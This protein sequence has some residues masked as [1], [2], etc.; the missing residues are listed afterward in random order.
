M[1]SLRDGICTSQSLSL[2]AMQY[3]LLEGRLSGY[4]PGTGGMF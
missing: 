4:E 1:L 2:D 3:L